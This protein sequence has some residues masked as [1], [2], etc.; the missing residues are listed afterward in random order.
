MSIWHGTCYF[1]CEDVKRGRN[2]NLALRQRTERVPEQAD[3]QMQPLRQYLFFL[4]MSLDRY[5]YLKKL[6]VPDIVLCMEKGLIDRQMLFLS[7]AC[8]ELTK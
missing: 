5:E 3:F 4:H 6:G 8:A 7:K 1:N 2:N